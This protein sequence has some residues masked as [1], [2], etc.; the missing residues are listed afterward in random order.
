[1]P[2]NRCSVFSPVICFIAI[3][4]SPFAVFFVWRVLLSMPCDFANPKP[5]FVR[6]PALSK[7]IATEG[8][9]ISSVTLS[10]S[11][12]R[13]LIKTTQPPWCSRTVNA[14]KCQTEIFETFTE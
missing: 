3:Q 14:L 12:G 10:C 13:P 4:Y 11:S 2:G 7:A 8:P 9:C 5:A 1:M 6:F